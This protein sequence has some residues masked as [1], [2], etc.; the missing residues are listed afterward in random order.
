[1]PL[2]P[3]PTGPRIPEVPNWSRSPNARRR[4]SS[5]PSR[6]HA[7]TCALVAGSG[8]SATHARAAA[9]AGYS[10]TAFA[11]HAPMVAAVALSGLFEDL[12][13]AVA[14]L[15]DAGVIRHVNAAA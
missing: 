2:G 13:V 11:Y 6:S 5:S 3:G 15:D 8:S 10:G 9:A 7:S 12:P 14:V 4:A 1:M